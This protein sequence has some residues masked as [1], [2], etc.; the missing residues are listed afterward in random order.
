MIGLLNCYRQSEDAPAYQLDYE[1]MFLNFLNWSVPKQKV[2]VYRV[3]LGQLPSHVTECQAWIIS[4]SPKGAYDSDQWIGELGKFIVA[5]DHAKARLLGVCF[6]HQLIAH[7]LGGRAEKSPNGWGVGVHGFKVNAFKSWMAPKINDAALLF[8][9]QDQVVTL[10]KAANHLA[11]SDFCKYQMYSVGEHI[12]SMQGHPE[13]TPEFA[14]GRLV[15]RQELIGKKVFDYAVK[16]LKRPTDAST[17][18]QWVNQ[19]LT[20]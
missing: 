15:S 4:G 10:P 14:M 13:F 18:G 3:P 8:S 12:F 7:V 2:K 17:V 20:R 9:H 19:F 5:A 6:G 11:T 16:S 1:P